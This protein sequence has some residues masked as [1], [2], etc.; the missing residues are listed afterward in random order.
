MLVS[1]RDLGSKFTRATN[2]LVSDS[3]VTIKLKL[4]RPFALSVSSPRGYPAIPLAHPFLVSAHCDSAH[5]DPLRR[6][7]AIDV[8]YTPPRHFSAIADIRSVNSLDVTPIETR[9]TRNLAT[10]QLRVTAWSCY[11]SL[12]E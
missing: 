11:V 12:S 10:V 5:C 8:S 6:H 9:H 2:C 4:P 1:Q 3:S 7:I